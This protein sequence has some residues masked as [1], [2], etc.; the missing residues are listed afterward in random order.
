MIRVTRLNGSELWLNPLLVET[1]EATP[2]SVI[3]M[4]NGH[5][6]VVVEDPGVITSK[7]IDIYRQIGLTRAV[8]QQEDR[9]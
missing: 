8:V 4:A 5:K 3:T 7:L 1:I 6:Y 2:D 9:P